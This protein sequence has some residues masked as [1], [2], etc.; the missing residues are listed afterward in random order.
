MRSIAA[1]LLA[2]ST[3]VSAIA[4]PPQPTTVI[5]VRH[6]EK[7]AATTM[8]S[9]VPLSDA[10]GARAKELARVL[11]GVPIDAIYTTP[12]Q[13][14]RQT[15]EP[16]AKDHEIEPVAIT[17]GDFYAAAVADLIRK[18]EA[19]QTVLVVGHSNTTP[20]VIRALGVASPPAISDSE[21]DDLFIVT[22]APGAAPRLIALRYGAPA[23]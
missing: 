21:Y 12:Y 4:A 23:R 11:A 5:L 8:S 2:L 22:L 18:K 9:D 13:R 15:A 1:T 3:A 14:T 16:V 7:T 19:G 17:A 10:G 20:A 6:A